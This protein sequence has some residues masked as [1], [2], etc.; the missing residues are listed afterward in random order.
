MIKSSSFKRPL[1]F[2]EI[3]TDN[4]FKSIMY[5]FFLNKSRLTH[6]FFGGNHAILNVF[7]KFTE[8]WLV[9]YQLVL[10]IV[11]I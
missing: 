1:V 10:N 7:T 8:N 11:Q 2:R 6:F 5:L 9:F 3:L 4:P